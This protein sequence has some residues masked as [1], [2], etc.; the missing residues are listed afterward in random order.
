MGVHDIKVGARKTEVKTID[1]YL[2]K[3]FISKHH[4]QPSHGA[5]EVAF[6]LYLNESLVGVMTGAK[7][8]RNGFSNLVLQRLCFTTKTQ[9]MG[10]ASKL[11]KALTSWA[12]DNNYN[13]IVSWSDNRIS[14]GNVYRKLGF[15]LKKE[16]TSDYSY[17]LDGYYDK[18][19][20]KQT[21]KKTPN[22]RLTG[23]SEYELRKEQG[24]YRIYDC[25]KKTWVFKV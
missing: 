9:I 24:Y 13:E 17:V 20:S 15:D 4:I 2:A 18:R 1:K 23:K 22:E 5:I 11:F 21:L 3:E 16:Y 12:K 25:G 6:G 19:H 14:E 10:G 8:H 7:H